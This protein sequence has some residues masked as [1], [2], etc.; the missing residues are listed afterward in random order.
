MPEAAKW[1]LLPK[2]MH[3]PEIPSGPRTVAAIPGRQILRCE[4][5]RGK[6]HRL[7]GLRAMATLRI[8]FALSLVVGL[9][10]SLACKTKPSAA[11]TTAGGASAMGDWDAWRDLSPLVEV[12]D[13]HA[14]PAIKDAIG[15]ASTLIREGKMR[16][17]EMHLRK[18][19]TSEGRNWVAA[20]RGDLAA[21]YFT[22]CIRGIAFRLQDLPQGGEP[23]SRRADFSEN[24]TIEPGDISVESILT[25]LDAAIASKVPPL[26]VQ[27]RIARARMAAYASQCPAN[28]E[29]ARM[30][31][32]T[33]KT[34]L[35]ILAAE[36]HL[37]PDLAYMWAGLQYAEFSGAAAKPF[38]LQARDAGYS[39]PMVTYMLAAIALEQLDFDNADKLAVEAIEIY[40]QL[41]DPMQ[42]AQCHFIRGEVARMRKQIGPAHQHYREAIKLVPTHVA[43][44]LGRTRLVMGE[45]GASAAVVHL[46]KLLPAL[47]FKGE[48]NPEQAQ[49]AAANLEALVV[50]AREPEMADLCRAALLSNVDGEPQALRRGIRYFYA[51]TLDA[52]LGEYEHARGHAIMAR[53]EFAETGLG[54]ALAEQVNAFL[55][56]IAAG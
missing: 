45:Q 3:W 40:R 56:Q 44:L 53:D 10:G 21:L 18:F 42:E 35:A 5:T 32:E 50:M 19:T 33:V 4:T 49:Q 43:S 55:A 24:T 38:L 39:D 48:L 46:E 34:D 30:T 13:T 28:A 6:T 11:P 41:G 26:V 54:E 1:Y 2:P 22:V 29:V 52:R 17:A 9:T 14:P 47:L 37:T 16:S 12:A 15:Q 20:A 31:E 23:P 7:I 27:A 51:A 25:D 36:G 8:C